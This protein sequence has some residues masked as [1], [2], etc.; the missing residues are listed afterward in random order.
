MH[1]HLVALIAIAFVAGCNQTEETVCDSLCRELVQVC[2][3]AAYPNLD[4]CRQGC[5]Y[6]AEQGA[7]IAGQ[8]QCIAE[9]ACDTF[10]IVECEHVHGIE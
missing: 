8:E 2:D 5:D 3:Y 9:A 1:K 4:S 10:A 6:A 7:D